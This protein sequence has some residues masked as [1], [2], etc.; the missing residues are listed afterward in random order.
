[1]N[2]ENILKEVEEKCISGMAF[3]QGVRNYILKAISLTEAK[4]I[5][6]VIEIIDKRIKNLRPEIQKAK[7]NWG[8]VDYETSKIIIYRLEGEF[9]ALEDLEREL[10]KELETLK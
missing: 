2:N 6:K 7:D 1:M 4:T 8:E 9:N 10:K 3:N 5:S